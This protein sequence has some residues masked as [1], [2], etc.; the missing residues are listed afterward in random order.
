MVQTGYEFS[1]DAV[2][3][4]NSNGSL[5]LQLA[6]NFKAENGPGLNVYLSN[7]SNG[8]TGA[9]ELGELKSIEGSQEYDVPSNV[10]LNSY[11][12]I[13]IYCKPFG[14][15]FGTAKLSN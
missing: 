11:D 15:A 3:A 14:V 5:T 9:V 4:T 6:N 1:G 7:S 13:V 10:A 2:L 8:I 12:H